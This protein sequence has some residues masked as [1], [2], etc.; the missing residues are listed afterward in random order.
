MR[1]FWV[2]ILP[3]VIFLGLNKIEVKF[4]ICFDIKY[5]LTDISVFTRG[6]SDIYLHSFRIYDVYIQVSKY[7]MS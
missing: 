7:K 5:S 1:S 6:N 2:R 3:K 4:M